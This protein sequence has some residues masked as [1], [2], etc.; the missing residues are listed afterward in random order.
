MIEI[1]GDTADL[2][3]L[4]KY[5]TLVHEDDTTGTG[6]IILSLGAIVTEV[7]AYNSGTV[8]IITVRT[9][10]A[11][12]AT[13]DTISATDNAVIGTWAAGA[14]L[15]VNWDNRAAASDRTTYHVPAGYGIEVALTTA[16]FETSVDGDG[17][18]KFL[19]MV[20]YVVVPRRVVENQ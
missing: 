2:Q 12:P 15:T 8:A 17:T 20:E 19:V 3:T 5:H 16:G 9:K 4:A 6:I 11:T 14:S 7:V 18:G 10:G 13:L 1:D